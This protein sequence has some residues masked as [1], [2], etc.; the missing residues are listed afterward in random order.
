[1]DDLSLQHVKDSFFYQFSKVGYVENCVFLTSRCLATAFEDHL[2]HPGY[3]YSFRGINFILKRQNASGVFEESSPLLEESSD[4]ETASARYLFKYILVTDSM[5]DAKKLSEILHDIYFN[6]NRRKIRTDVLLVNKEL[7]KVAQRVDSFFKSY[8][9][10]KQYKIAHHRG[11]L[12]YGSAGAGKTCWAHY[13]ANLYPDAIIHLSGDIYSLK[14]FLSEHKGYESFKKII[15]IDEFESY[16]CGA[17]GR[18]KFLETLENAPDNCLFIATT[19]RPEV[20]GAEF[21]DRPGRF[22]ECIYVGFPSMSEIILFLEN[23]GAAELARF[24]EGFSFA[25]INELIYRVKINKEDPKRAQETINQPKKGVTIPDN[26]APIGFENKK[27]KHDEDIENIDEFEDDE[28]SSTLRQLLNKN[29]WDFSDAIGKPL[30][31]DKNDG[32]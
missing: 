28:L 4:D 10:Y 8:D 30:E 6:Y 31:E 25:H 17:S 14:D 9:H 32:K 20:L 7:K 26:K 3:R 21:Y 23:K 1:M 24:C 29:D 27:K 18:I 16:V 5:E 19:N 15:I 2:L 13:I 22:D 12:L 11:I